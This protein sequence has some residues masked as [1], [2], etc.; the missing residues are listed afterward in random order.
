MIRVPCGD[1]YNEASEEARSLFHET[2]QN[3]MQIRKKNVENRAS[4]NSLLH[5]RMFCKTLAPS[6]V[7]I[8]TLITA[9][10]NVFGNVMKH[11]LMNTT[12]N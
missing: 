10:A 2:M 6:V 11:L 4:R 9:G 8:I 1:Y 5:R 3:E 12:S 7:T